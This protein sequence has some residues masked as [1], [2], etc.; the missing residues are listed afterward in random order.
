[1]RYLMREN[2][3]PCMERL[4]L[5]LGRSGCAYQE[6]K[7]DLSFTA[8]R[9]MLSRRFLEIPDFRQEG[10]VEHRV[11]DVLMSGFAMMFYQDSSLL[12][13][14]QRLEEAI[15]KNNLRTLFQVESLPKDSQMREVIDEIALYQECRRAFG[16]RRSLWDHLRASIRLLIFPD[17]DTLLKRLLRPSDFL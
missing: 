15:H 12:Q 5:I 1:M 6:S 13:F 14:Q 11:H 7:K 17:W 8:L 4:R 3:T 10:K 16:S 9:R 2:T